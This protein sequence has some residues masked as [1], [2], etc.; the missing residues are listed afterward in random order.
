VLATSAAAGIPREH[1]LDVRLVPFEAEFSWHQVNAFAGSPPADCGGRQGAAV[2]AAVTST[3]SGSSTSTS[4]RNRTS[5]GT[6]FE[7][8]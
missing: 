3:S 2:G 5:W 6:E 7:W 1:L 8:S 4:P